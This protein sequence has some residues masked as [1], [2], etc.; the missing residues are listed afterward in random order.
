MELK[1]II[2]DDEADGRNVLKT[3]LKQFCPTVTVCD[4]AENVKDAYQAIIKNIP[5]IVFLDVQMPKEN[6]FDLLKKFSEIPFE[7]I[8]VTSYD[9]YAIEAFRFS[10]LDFLLKPVEVAELQRAVKKLEK[11]IFNKGLNEQVANLL[12][13]I[14]NAGMEKKIA[15][16]VNDRV[17]LLPLSEITHM[18][19][20]RNYSIIHT[21]KGENY[22]SSKNLGEFE[23]LFEQYPQ[24]MRIGKG[25][26]ANLNHVSDYSKGEPCILTIANRLSFEITRRKKQEVIERLL[27]NK[28][29]EE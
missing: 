28:K 10:A 27:R 22:T 29:K 2:V 15:V 14:E 19:G 9:T 1:A 25:C 7:I 8:F 3:L 11:Q 4:E 21:I 5:D 24:F 13:H 26:I 20:E 17:V 12:Q 16:H 23:E 6:G 18:E